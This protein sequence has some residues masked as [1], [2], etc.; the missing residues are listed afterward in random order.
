MTVQKSETHLFLIWEYARNKE[1]DILSDIATQF[2]I[3]NV[4]DIEWSKETFA[5]NLTRFYGQNLP[6]NSHKELH[7]GKGAFLLIIV[8]DQNPIYNTRDTSHGQCS[9]NINMFDKKQLYRSWTGGGHRI[10]ATD[11]KFE[12]NHNLTLLL[13]INSEDYKKKY[14][15]YWNQKITKIA[16]D[17]PGTKQWDSI[18]ELFY[19]LNN[20]VEYV[21]LR[22]FEGLPDEYTMKSHGDI[23]LM[24]RNPIE[25]KY[26]VNAKPVFPNS[27]RVLHYAMV[28][29]EKVLFDFRFC[30][31]NYYDKRW[32][33]D[34]IENRYL[35]QEGFY[36]PNR[37]DYFYS[38][39][40]H[41]LVHKP[42]IAE[43]YKQRLP[44]IANEIGLNIAYH[45]FED[46]NYLNELLSK[47]LKENKYV[48][49]EPN[50]LSVYLNI[51][52]INI[53]RISIPRIFSFPI[54]LTQK[55]KLILLQT[56]DKSV[57]S[58]EFKRSIYLNNFIL[59]YHFSSY[60]H[61]P[62]KI[63]E[64]PKNSKVIEL[65]SET[66]VITRYLGEQFDEVLAIEKDVDSYEAIRIRCKDLS[67]VKIQNSDYNSLNLKKG[68]DLAIVIVNMNQGQNISLL[69]IEIRK[70]ITLASNCLKDSG[71]L[72]FAVE[73]QN[74][75]RND[76]TEN[77]SAG[78]SI[79]EI[80]QLLSNTNFS[81]HT[82]FYA[83]PDHLVGQNFF[84]DEAINLKSSAISQW[85]GSIISHDSNGNRLPIDDTL[86]TLKKASI[87]GKLGQIAN[88][89]III[90]SKSEIDK[91][92]W[93]VKSF[94]G[95]SRRNDAW[96]ETVLLK[97]DNKLIVEKKDK[98]LRNR[99]STSIQIV[100]LSF[101][102]D[103]VEKLLIDSIIKSDN[104][105][106]LTY[107]KNIANILLKIIK[108]KI[109]YLHYAEI[110]IF[111]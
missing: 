44:I 70:K 89:F 41:A 30:G 3:L 20:S 87:N 95:E 61:L 82:K 34:I 28:N 27:P 104:I 45:N 57:H 4:F 6:S 55:I 81:F 42:N 2:S 31:D 99:H 12:V 62:I 66:G 43:D 63:A 106:F 33:N 90:A 48:Y 68:F 84:T 14:P 75:Y 60:R 59:R 91:K 86:N 54:T 73:N 22:N 35:T 15:G 97:D 8:E 74:C 39:L 71:K 9:V 111:F 110:R 38:L 64:L 76:F 105:H 13:G 83:F 69:K 100:E 85:A 52:N 109:Q 56:S 40:Y 37:K 92:T 94:N 77:K 80:N 11:N 96:T 23:D 1:F 46:P 50:D 79:E 36:R 101:E 47:Y 65:G 102:G 21:V 72:I 78:Y 32:Q 49:T 16:T 19:V 103:T 98:K 5:T 29:N 18:K 58:S 107:W 17:P 26:M 88:S 7:C 53:N 67:N 24:T 25:L 10:H 108:I 93:L 51:N